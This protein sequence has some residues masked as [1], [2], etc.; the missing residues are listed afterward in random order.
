MTAQETTQ[1][2]DRES[3]DGRDRLS[4]KLLKILKE[5]EAGSGP[6]DTDALARNVLRG[7]W[8]ISEEVDLVEVEVTEEEIEELRKLEEL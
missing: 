6:V 8:D 4:A 7:V 2:V 5:K 3:I 1:M